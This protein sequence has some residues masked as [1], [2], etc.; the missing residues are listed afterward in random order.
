MLFPIPLLYLSLV[1]VKMANAQ[2]KFL[3][4]NN[5]KKARSGGNEYLHMYLLYNQLHVLLQ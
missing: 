3:R 1:K 2:I 5:N 4:F